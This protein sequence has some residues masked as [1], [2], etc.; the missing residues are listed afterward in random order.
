MN[1]TEFYN[2]FKDYFTNAQIA[3]IQ[4]S[5]F[6]NFEHAHGYKPIRK[7]GKNIAYGFIRDFL[8]NED[9]SVCLDYLKTF[10]IPQYK[11][12][13]FLESLDATCEI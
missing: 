2:M 9:F 13:E 6:D 4:R 10:G 8:Y 11:A 1:Y 12:V 7:S 3:K 5:A